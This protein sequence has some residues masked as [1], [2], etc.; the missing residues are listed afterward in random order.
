LSRCV[1]HL[2][3]SEAWSVGLYRTAQ[4]LFHRRIEDVENK[5]QKIFRDRHIRD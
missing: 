1:E 2:S 4:R 5:F 3:E